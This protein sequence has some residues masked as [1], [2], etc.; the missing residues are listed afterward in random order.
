MHYEILPLP[1]EKFMPE[2][3]PDGD[4]Q[5]MC[6]YLK[7]SAQQGTAAVLLI[8]HLPLVGYL[9]ALLCPEEKSV[10]MSTSAIAHVELDSKIGT[11]TLIAQISPSQLMLPR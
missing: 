7:S 2:L 5:W 4:A 3:T 1:Q 11:G 6:D 9:V 10:T 8:S